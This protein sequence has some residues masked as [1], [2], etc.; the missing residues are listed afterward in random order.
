MNKNKKEDEI[1]RSVIIHK[2]EE[3]HMNNFDDRMKA[4]MNKL[5]ELLE[6]GMKIQMP[7]ISKIHRIG[8]YNPDNKVKYRQIKVVFTDNITRDKVIRNASNLKQADD[9]YKHCYIRKDLN[10][11]E[12]N[13]F[14]KKMEN[15]Q[16][17][18]NK[19][20]NNDKF[21]VVRGYPS[22]WKIQEKPRRK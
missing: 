2:L 22:N 5:S 12:R 1:K 17:L 15:A 13:E 18:N 4:D 8:K 19:E 21:F 9:K 6:K 20:E 11:D 3:I 7:E 16:E 14:T 10:Q